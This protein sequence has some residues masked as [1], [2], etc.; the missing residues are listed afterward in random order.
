MTGNFRNRRRADFQSR[1]DHWVSRTQLTPTRVRFRR[2]TRLWGV[3]NCDNSITFATAL[4]DQPLAFQDL[5]IV[6]ELIHLLIRDHGKY[7]RQV[8]ELYQPD[9]RAVTRL[10]PESPAQCRPLLRVE[11]RPLRRRPYAGRGMSRSLSAA[12][13]V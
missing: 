8:L 5:V 11:D 7:F 6:H 3:C 13:P 1:L 9:W 2:M 10:A 12:A 4:L